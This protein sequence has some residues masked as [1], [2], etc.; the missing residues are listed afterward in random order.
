MRLKEIFT[1]DNNWCDTGYIIGISAVGLFYHWSHI[2]TIVF[3]V[4]LTYFM[5]KKGTQDER[6]VSE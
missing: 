1:V 2:I 6:K 5:K 4:I 3:T